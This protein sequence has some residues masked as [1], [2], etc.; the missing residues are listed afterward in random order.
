MAKV[1]KPVEAAVVPVLVQDGDA[2]KRVAAP[3]PAMEKIKKKEE[4]VEPSAF[5]SRRHLKQEHLSM[6]N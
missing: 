5:A 2:S 1:D 6:P 4:R 3:Q